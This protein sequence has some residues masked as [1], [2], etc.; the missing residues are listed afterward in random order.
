[1]SQNPQET[2]TEVASHALL[3]VAM[4]A[5][6]QCLQ[7]ATIGV[8]SLCNGCPPLCEG[9]GEPK[10]H[11]GKEATS[12][13]CCSSCY[14]KLPAWLKD[15]RSSGKALMWENRMAVVLM[16]MRD[17]SSPNDSGL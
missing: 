15:A 4:S 8:P 2:V 13:V 9:C 5:N 7:E 16:W 14:R 11:R 17:A 12:L 3:G 1:M 10:L 6:G